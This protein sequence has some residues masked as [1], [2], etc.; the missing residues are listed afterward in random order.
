M[1]LRK[2]EWSSTPC[3]AWG[4]EHLEEQ[5]A[6]PADHHRDNI[7]MD[8]PDRRIALEQR[9]VRWW[10]RLLPA[11][12]IVEHRADAA[13]QPLADFLGRAGKRHIRTI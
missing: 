10:H 13:D 3:S 1:S 5:P 7:G 9:I 4:V 6:H 11:L 2:S 12:D 8:Q